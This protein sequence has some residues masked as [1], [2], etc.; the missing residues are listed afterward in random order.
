ML[1]LSH[2]GRLRTCF[3]SAREPLNASALRGLG[4][5]MSKQGG[6]CVIVKLISKPGSPVGLFNQPLRRSS[7]ERPCETTRYANSD[8]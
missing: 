1:R 2:S 5:V 6:L 4:L 3:A 7:N 8:L